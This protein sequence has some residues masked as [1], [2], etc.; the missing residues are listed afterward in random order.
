MASILSVI[1]R[2]PSGVLEDAVP[3]LTAE[4]SLET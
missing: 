3:S 4:A 1:Q 2:P